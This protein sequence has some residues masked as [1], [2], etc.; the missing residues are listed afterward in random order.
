VLL[1]VGTAA[2]FVPAWRAGMTDPAIA[3]REE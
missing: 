2:A 1:A 3:L